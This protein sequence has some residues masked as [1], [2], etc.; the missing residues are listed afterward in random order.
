MRSEATILNA[1]THHGASPVKVKDSGQLDATRRR[2]GAVMMAFVVCLACLSL[3]LLQLSLLGHFDG[4][5]TMPAEL[6]AGAD[7]AALLDRNGEFLATD[8]RLA[9]LYANPKEIWD[10]EETIRKL[11]GLFPSLDVA[12]LHVR[13]TSPRQFEWIKRDLTP[14]EEQDV[15]AL[16]LPGLDFVA[17][18]HRVYPAKQELA[19]ILGYVD[20]DNVGIAGIEKGLDGRI[21]DTAAGPVRLSIDL[22]AQHALRD[23]M[24]AAMVKFRAIA[25]AGIVMDAANGEIVALVSLPDF[26]P[27][28]P[29][30]AKPNALFNRATLGVYEMGSTFKAVTTAMALDSGKVRLGDRFDA[31]KPMKAGPFLI[32]DFHPENRW[33]TVSEIFQY[34]SN[35]GSARM[36]LKLGVEAHRKFVA[37]LGLT[38]TPKI[39]LPEVGR[40]L[41]PAHWRELETMTVAYGHGIA[42]SPLQVVMATASL[43]NGG[44]LISPT[45]LSRGR[46]VAEPG[47]RVISPNTS[48]VMRE[49]L[50]EVVVSGTGSKA[51]V[52][53]YAVGGKTGTAE[54][55]VG[56]SYAKNALM[57]SFLAVFPAIA[58]RYVMLIVLDE[59]KPAEDTFGFA[60]AG[61]T[62][63]P[64][65]AKVI[66]RIAPIL[67][68]SPVTEDGG[69]VLALN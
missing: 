10:V 56:G 55:A 13:L 64:T 18:A 37:S 21:R 58:P 1:R 59:P 34:S 45:L 54:K 50:R 41:V 52:P 27:N 14:K 53:G 61:W 28:E 66:A 11:R 16:G 60:T 51:D 29:G 33:L 65:A 26:D 40:P 35:I 31:S 43:V 67:R 49:L 48:R 17:E 6:R 8:I 9:S 12:D 7:R 38:S 63:A 15:F 19:H 62:A 5:T 46:N 68:V 23:E 24:Q 3:R 47:Q 39:E 44:N 69:A 57:S 4:V 30:K 42:V 2:L 20:S 36:A 32:H 22:G 25:A